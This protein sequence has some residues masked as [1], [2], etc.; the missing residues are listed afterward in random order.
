MPK[1]PNK[2]QIK[3]EKTITITLTES[4]ARVLAGLFQNAV[5]NCQTEEDWEEEPQEITELREWIFEGI[6]NAEEA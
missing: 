1:K 3:T 4:E 6:T 5:M 2:V